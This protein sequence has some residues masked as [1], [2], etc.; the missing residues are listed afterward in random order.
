MALVHSFL[1]VTSVGLI[2]E[3]DGIVSPFL[4]EV[5]SPNLKLLWHRWSL[6]VYV[7]LYVYIYV[8][9]C[10]YVCV[11]VLQCSQ[12]FLHITGF[13]FTG[14]PCRIAECSCL[15]LFICRFT[16]NYGAILKK[17]EIGKA[18]AWLL[19]SL[20]ILCILPVLQWLGY[21]LL[22]AELG[23]SYV[24]CQFFQNQKWN[25]AYDL[26]QAGVTVMW[27]EIKSNY[28]SWTFGTTDRLAKF[29]KFGVF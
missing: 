1:F 19:C 3:V 27:C 13:L 7:G 22:F 28:V 25:I 24:I 2:L 26:L 17:N 10:M 21:W 9:V 15:V 5:F 20:S 6:L 23:I 29:L 4:F 14:I 18:L 16:G 11:R 8:C 12:V